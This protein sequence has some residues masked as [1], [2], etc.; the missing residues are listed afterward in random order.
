MKISFITDFSDILEQVYHPCG[1]QISNLEL[2][3]ESKEYEACSFQLNA[4][5]VKAR[6][7]KIT[8][9]KIGHFVTLWKRN[10]NGETTPF[11]DSDQIDFFVITSRE[12]LHLGQF[13]FP[14]S[15]LM[16]KGIVTHL[17]KEGKRGFRV[18]P[19]WAIPINKTAQK[20]QKWQLKYFLNIDPN[21]KTDLGKAKALY[22]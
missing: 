10:R 1:L 4:L 13:I 14:K 3:S 7:S 15:V 19:P 17:K 22:L 8:P 11:E 5:N 6:R 12:G 20:T 21:F 18:Y 16:E 2:D 9:K